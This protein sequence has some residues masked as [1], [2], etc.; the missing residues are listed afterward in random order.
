VTILEDLRKLIA[1][2]T[3]PST[4]VR[5]AEQAAMGALRIIVGHGVK[6]H[7]PE[8]EEE[9]SPKSAPLTKARMLEIQDE[10]IARMEQDK[11]RENVPPPPSGTYSRWEPVWP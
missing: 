1:E 8:A 3:N 5:T 7:L 2:A 4:P 11:E 9:P 10:V 6:M